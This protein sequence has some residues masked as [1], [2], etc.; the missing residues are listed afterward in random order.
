MGGHFASSGG[1]EQPSSDLVLRF[2]AASIL[3]SGG[4]AQ[5]SDFKC[6]ASYNWLDSSDP[7]IMVPGT[8]I[9]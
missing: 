5:M 8:F 3:P 9:P 7:V 6:I 2:N 4:P 1:D